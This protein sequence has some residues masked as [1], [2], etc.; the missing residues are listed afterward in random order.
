MSD[1]GIYANYRLCRAKLL[2]GRGSSP[3]PTA[4]PLEVVR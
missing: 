1:D 2:A 3:T 4:P